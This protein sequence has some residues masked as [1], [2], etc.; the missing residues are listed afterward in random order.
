VTASASRVLG[1]VGCLVA[2]VAITSAARAQEDAAGPDLEFL[3]YLGSW[4]GSDAEW[5][6]IVDWNDRNADANK[7]EDGD[8]PKQDKPEESNDDA[9]RG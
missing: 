5:P 2:S 6:A 4:Q 9:D 1:W 3:E 7:G 8:E